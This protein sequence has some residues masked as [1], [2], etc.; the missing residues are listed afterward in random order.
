M[1][2]VSAPLGEIVRLRLL[3]RGAKKRK[4]SEQVDDRAVF[5]KVG[6]VIR[7]KPASI[8]LSLPGR[9]GGEE[10]QE[11]KL[12]YCVNQVILVL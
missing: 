11:D 6:T 9:E 4:E 12:G 10:N 1:T 5:F 2:S 3:P 7:C 8:S